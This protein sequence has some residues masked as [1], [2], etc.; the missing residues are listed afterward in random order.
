MAYRGS[1]LVNRDVLA[2]GRRTP[3]GA[4]PDDLER[5]AC[6]DNLSWSTGWFV[7]CWSDGGFW[8]PRRVFVKGRPKPPFSSLISGGLKGVDLRLSNTH[9]RGGAAPA[10]YSVPLLSIAN[11]PGGLSLQRWAEMRNPRE[12]ASRAAFV[13]QNPRGCIDRRSPEN[14][15][16]AKWQDHKL[17]GISHGRFSLRVTY[18]IKPD[19]P[20]RCSED[21]LG[22]RCLQRYQHVFWLAQ[23]PRFY[24]SA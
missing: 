21:V 24:L 1:P 22:N 14:R 5:G 7:R 2:V 19:Q 12:H 4:G 18:P 23:V 16:G 20:G 6:G 17:N 11:H 10:R 9:A 13:A 15:Q 3:N 8:A